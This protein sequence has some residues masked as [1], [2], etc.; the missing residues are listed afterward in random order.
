M[1]EAVSLDEQARAILRRND[2]GG[3]TVPTSGLYPY[4]WNWDSAF[5]ALGFARF[6]P[7]RAWLELETLF[8]GQWTNGM[9]PHIVFHEYAEGYFPG[10]AV[11]GT[12]TDPPSSGISQPPVAATS[13][14]ALFE[15]H[16]DIGRERLPALMP[17]FLA[18]HRWF[19]ENRAESGAI[20]A[21]HPW[22][23]GR[24]NAP[25]W[26]RA[27]LR[28]D[29]SGVGEYTRHDISHVAPDMRPTKADYDAYLALV[30]FGAACGWDEDE[31]R[32]GGPF[33]VADPTLTFTLLRAC[34]DLAF[35]AGELGRDTAEVDGWTDRLVDGA[36]TLWN[37]E[38]RHYDARDLRSGELSGSLS[39]ASFL[40]WFAG[41][42]SAD[43]LDRYRE[44]DSAVR[45]GVPSFSPGSPAFNPRRYWRG[46]AWAM[47][48]ALIGIGL[49]DAGHRR[50]AEKLRRDTRELI[51]KSGFAEYYDPCDG[52]PAGGEDFTWTAAVW[53]AWASPNAEGR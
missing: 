12:D 34:R 51:G 44:V 31:I 6:D 33:R 3:Y 2:R 26:D 16:P 7:E 53:L 4:Q 18:W 35:L 47:M 15:R 22:E 32:R 29:T 52:T 8:S 30:N 42:D 43:M 41:L 38:A 27:I 10:P 17:K 40:C 24:D 49:A 50:E 28:V 37:P 46:P 5:A 1:H 19:M 23:T 14:R 13:A 36:A 9:V 20:A 25:D 45:Y 48:N 11:W 21:I 39:N